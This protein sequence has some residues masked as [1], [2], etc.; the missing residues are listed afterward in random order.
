MHDTRNNLDF[1]SLL[2]TMEAGLIMQLG[3]A[4]PVSLEI[5]PALNIGRILAEG[6][7]MGTLRRLPVSWL[8]IHVGLQFWF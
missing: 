7:A 8:S 3:P 5:A 2:L 6:E 4:S 1:S